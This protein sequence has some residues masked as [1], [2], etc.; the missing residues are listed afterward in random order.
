MHYVDTLIKP[1]IYIGAGLLAVGLYVDYLK[2]DHFEQVG[3][4]VGN[5]T[6]LDW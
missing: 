5:L 3:E 2:T 6:Q 1:S 4:F